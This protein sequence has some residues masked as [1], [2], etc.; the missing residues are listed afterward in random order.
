MDFSHTQYSLPY[1]D[2]N[3]ESLDPKTLN[4]LYQLDLFS[5]SL[6]QNFQ[7]RFKD[8]EIYLDRLLTMDLT[9]IS[10]IFAYQQIPIVED[11]KK[12]F[13]NGSLMIFEKI[14]RKFEEERNIN[15]IPD[16]LLCQKIESTKNQ[17]FFSYNKL[18]QSLAVT[19]SQDDSL[20]VAPARENQPV[21]E[22]I[23]PRNKL[24]PGKTK[25]PKK[26][27]QILEA[28]YR[29][30]A[31]DPFPSHSEKQ[32]LADESGITL[33][34]VKCWFINMRRKKLNKVGEDTDFKAQI[35]KQLSKDGEPQ[36]IYSH[37]GNT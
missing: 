21:Q 11:A 8:L 30:H 12:G 1:K 37:R 32:R 2:P 19:I 5:F 28:W 35:E 16:S 4:H 29:S 26:A 15:L 6:E 23:K 27:K 34:Q 13:R 7:N 9:V 22:E 10:P 20:L 33:K 31:D 3:P 14:K 24:K 17:L 25:F 18:I 36:G